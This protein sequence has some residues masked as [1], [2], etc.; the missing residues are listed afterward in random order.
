MAR[1]FGLV[2]VAPF[3]S[4]DSIPFSLKS[5]FAFLVSLILFPVVGRYL[6]EIP[7]HIANYG[8]VVL[9]E[10]FVGL[11]LGFLISIVFAAFQMAGEFFN[12]QIGF[13]YT[14]LLDPVSQSSL[15]VIS[16]LKNLMATA[17]FLVIG[18]HRYL[19][20]TL[21]FSFEK[22]RFFAFTPQI[23][24]GLSSILKDAIGAMFV[25]SFKIALPVM[26]ILFL[27]SLAEGLMGKAA[28]QMN[29]MSLS[30][31]LKVFIGVF[32]LV[33]TLSFISSQMIQGIQISF[34]KTQVFIQGW[35]Q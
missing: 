25:V 9:G 1:I 30:F 24:Q 15:P 21:A 26:A 20:E 22:I 34:D 19:I 31:P 28:Q 12:S 27:V 6:P 18:G 33:A 11:I 3:Y 32:T 17:L 14:E 4:S 13:G 2:L 35:P 29:V 23:N 8:L 5:I 10:L 16:T 7:T